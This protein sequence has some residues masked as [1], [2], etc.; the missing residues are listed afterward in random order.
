MCPTEESIFDDAI[1]KLLM[2]A[3]IFLYILKVYMMVYIITKFCRS[4]LSQSK[5]KVE[6]SVSA[7][8]T[9]VTLC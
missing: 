6:R 9:Q 2:S 8:R 7:L 4:S 5:V 3:K 1:R